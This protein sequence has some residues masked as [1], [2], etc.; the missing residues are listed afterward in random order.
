MLTTKLTKPHHGQVRSER[1]KVSEDG[2]RILSLGLEL[3]GA[4]AIRL[5]Q[6]YARSWSAGLIAQIKSSSDVSS[7]P[8]SFPEHGPDAPTGL[9][10]KSQAAGEHLGKKRSYSKGILGIFKNTASEWMEDK[11]PQLGAA[12]AYFTVFSLAPL[13]LVFLAV[14]A[15]SSAAASMHEK[16]S[17]NSCSILSTR[18]G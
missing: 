1:I 14:L 6:R 11:C 13:V 4:V 9:P 18:A 8:P 7:G 2:P 10:S 17:P 15:C 12:L 3:L 16:R 5:A